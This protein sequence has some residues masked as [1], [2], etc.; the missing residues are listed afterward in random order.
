MMFYNLRLH[1]I[2]PN[3][4]LQVSAFTFLCEAYLHVDEDILLRKEYN[5]GSPGDFLAFYD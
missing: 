4:L 2:A 1:D 3:S 5:A